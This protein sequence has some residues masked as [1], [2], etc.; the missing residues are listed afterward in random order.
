MI[1]LGFGLKATLLI[2]LCYGSVSCLG[3]AWNVGQ[4]R[5]AAVG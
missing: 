5:R 1:F 2:R 3:R 4:T